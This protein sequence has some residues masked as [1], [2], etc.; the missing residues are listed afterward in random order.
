M[1][2]TPQPPTLHPIIATLLAYE[3][4]VYSQQAA[5]ATQLLPHLLGALSG[6]E[7]G[8]DIHGLFKENT[9]PEIRRRLYTKV[10]AAIMC[11]MRSPGLVISHEEFCQL[12]RHKASAENIFNLGG[13]H[14]PIVLL[15]GLSQQRSDGSTQLP[16][17]AGWILPIFFSLDDIPDALFRFV[18]QGPTEKR[19]PLAVGWLSSVGTALSPQGVARLTALQDAMKDAGSLDADTAIAIVRSLTTAW[20]YCSYSATENKHQAKKALNAVWQII[21]RKENVT[22]KLPERKQQRQ[23]PLILVAAE[24]MK[25]GHA[26]HR[27]YAPSLAQLRQRFE[28]HLLVADIYYQAEGVEELFDGVTVIPTRQTTLREFVAQVIRKAPD[29]ILYPSLGMSTWSMALCN[30]RLAPVQIMLLGHPAPAMSDA[31]DYALLQNSHE[32]AADSFDCKVVIRSG[33]G[34]MAP[35][36]VLPTPSELRDV[37]PSDVLNIAVNSSALK[38]SAQF[39]SAC[40]RIQQAS[41]RPLHFHF[42]TGAKGI[43]LESLR[44]RL[45]G[46]FTRCTLHPQMPY[47]DYAATLSK[48]DLALAAFPF[49]N[50]N[51]TVDTCLLGIPLVAFY[52]DSEVL[53]MGDKHIMTDVGMPDWLL[54]ADEDTYCQAALRLISD[55]QLRL[56]IANQLRSTDVAARLF[57]TPP[58]ETDHE[59][60]DSVHWVYEHHAQLQAS[61]ARKF[62]VGQTIASA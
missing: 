31:I 44:N 11:H 51:S 45:E 9:N 20:M 53:S 57:S 55:D 49:G 12:C 42:F 50:T 16:E 60:V 25:A 18:L 28:V 43:R 39:I 3:Q 59:F 46:M 40:Q 37:G 62:V 33:D 34:Y 35:P 38:I 10:S 8:R 6:D 5:R 19:I 41:T 22:A 26:M 58:T 54:A 61:K 14:G 15:E 24:R 27:S 17:W 21:L 36:R 2:P 29:L 13:Y 7:N 32:A 56:A 4:A 47:Q 30:L 52:A 1:S 48:C 23:R